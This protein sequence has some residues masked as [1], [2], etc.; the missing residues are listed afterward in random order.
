MP[1]DNWMLA[2]SIG[3]I[4]RQRKLNQKRPATRWQLMA[5]DIG[6]HLTNGNDLARSQLEISC[7]IELLSLAR[8]KS[9]L[10]SSLE[11]HLSAAISRLCYDTLL[12]RSSLNFEAA[13][14][15]QWGRIIPHFDFKS[16]KESLFERCEKGYMRPAK[17]VACSRQRRPIGT[18]VGG[19]STC[20]P[21]LDVVSSIVSSIWF[22]TFAS[23]L[24]ETEQEP[25]NGARFVCPKIVSN[26]L[27]NFISNKWLKFNNH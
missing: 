23:W 27:D 8:F 13:L 5:R 3:R 4:S 20:T 22:S 2:R 21:Q 19:T 25:L 1:N 9:H 10:S 26:C 16:W 24:I 14:N 7:M 12:N 6:S 17:Q 11:S 18:F 15:G